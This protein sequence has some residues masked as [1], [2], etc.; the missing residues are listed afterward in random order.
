M[1][2]RELAT[3]SLQIAPILA[4]GAQR[5]ADYNPALRSA[6]VKAEGER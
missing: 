4:T 1:P 6:A 5:T 2:P 3:S